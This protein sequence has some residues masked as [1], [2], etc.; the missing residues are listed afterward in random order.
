MSA[1]SIKSECESHIALL[2]NQFST[3]HCLQSQE[4]QAVGVCWLAFTL[5]K[6]FI[7]CAVQL[8][9]VFVLLCASHAWVEPQSEAFRCALAI[10]VGYFLLECD[11]RTPV[12]T[13]RHSTGET[14]RNQSQMFNRKSIS[15]NTTHRQS[16]HLIQIEQDDRTDDA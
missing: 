13:W 1:T 7:L 11:Y 9:C 15:R 10:N 5:Q 2:W 12:V 16:L 8:S 4:Y 3:L 6:G 14:T